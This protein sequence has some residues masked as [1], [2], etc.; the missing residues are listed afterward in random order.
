MTDAIIQ[1]IKRQ[2]TER[3]VTLAVPGM[4]DKTAEILRSAFGQICGQDD[5]RGPINAVVPVRL[6]SLYCEAIRFM[7]ATEPTQ[8]PVDD[9]HV[10]LVSVG[11][12]MGPAGP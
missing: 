3:R 7:T 8:E 11:Y 12:R 10:R 6:V 1:Q 4:D 2:Y 9:Y 5:W